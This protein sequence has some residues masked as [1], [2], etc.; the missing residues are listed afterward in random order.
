MVAVAYT[1]PG[2]RLKEVSV[3][4]E[5]TVHRDLTGAYQ[6]DLIMT[7]K[8]WGFCHISRGRSEEWKNAW[9]R[10]IQVVR[11]TQFLSYR[12]NNTLADQAQYEVEYMRLLNFQNGLHY[13]GFA[14]EF[15]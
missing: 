10:F 8:I 14:W 6:M 5:L 1:P 15:R 3:K 4:R 2:V 7:G 13:K 9:L 12:P 11:L